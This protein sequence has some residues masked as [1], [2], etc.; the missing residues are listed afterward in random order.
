LTRCKKVMFWV[1]RYGFFI[2]L[3][4]FLVIMIIMI[5]SHTVQQTALKRINE[6]V[7]TTE[8]VIQE[9][10][11]RQTEL[12]LEAGLAAAA[13]LGEDIAG[14]TEVT[15]R[16]I[17]EIN[18]V[19]SGILAEMEKRTLDSLYNETILMETEQEAEKL[20]FEGKYAQASVKYA[21]VAEAQPENRQARFYYLY[22]MFLSNK[23]DRSNYRR[24]KEGLQAL[25]RN[26][27]LRT[28]IRETL[29]FIETEERGLVTGGAE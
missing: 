14:G 9:Q 8:A 7:K 17:Q 29:R 1:R 13:A 6:Q 22:S 4:L 18:A 16:R 20:F 19:Y 12:L 21:V 2:M 11:I 28:E 26:G 3:V 27:Y 10:L 5:W 25:E 23:L 24:I 15:G